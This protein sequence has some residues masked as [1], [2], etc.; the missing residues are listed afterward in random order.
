MVWSN[1]KLEWV[2]QCPEGYPWWQTLSRG[3]KTCGVT[4][5]EIKALGK[6]RCQLIPDR[7]V[8]A[9][10]GIL[11][12]TEIHGYS[13]TNIKNPRLRWNLNQ[14]E[15]TLC[16]SFTL[17]T[18]SYQFLLY[19]HLHCMANLLNFFFSMNIGGSWHQ[20]HGI[21]AICSF[22]LHQILH[23]AMPGGVHRAGPSH[24]PSS[25]L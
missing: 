3:Q 15:F 8:T 11:T 12:Q 20:K 7:L 6:R 22:I 18:K 10:A 16:C 21:K 4:S 2:S 14:K 9:P 1:K 13:R 25:K 17:N 24:H 19:M 5:R 23:S